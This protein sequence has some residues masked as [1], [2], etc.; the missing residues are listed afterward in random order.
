MTRTFV[1]T[2]THIYI[3]IYGHMYILIILKVKKKE[4][5]K[6]EVKMK[7]HLLPSDYL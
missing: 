4:L 7:L 3:P 2:Y 5:E 6:S 1:G